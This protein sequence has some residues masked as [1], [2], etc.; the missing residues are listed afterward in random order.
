MRL[1]WTSGLALALVLVVSGC[2][3]PST[4]CDEGCDDGIACTVDSC[5]EV[6]GACRH[7]PDHGQCTQPEVCD[8]DNGCTLP[9]GACTNDAACDDT[10]PCTSDT[11]NLTSGSCVHG[12]LV[13]QSCD[14]G[15]VCTDGDECQMNGRCAG[16]SMQCEDGDPCTADSCDPSTLG[17]ISVPAA[18]A[19]CSDGDACTTGDVCQADGSCAG[20][21]AVTC[22]DGNECTNDSCDPTTG[23]VAQ[24]VLGGACDDGDA[25]T[26]G[27]TCQADG[28]CGGGSGVTCDDSNPCT[29]DSCDLGGNCVYE[30][31]PGGAC[32]DSDLCTESTT[33]QA[34]GSCGGGT[35]V[36]C[37]RGNG[38]ETFSC[39]PASGCIYTP[40]TGA[41]CDDNDA[42][43]SGTT[44]Q[45]DAS[46]GGGT[47]TNCGDGNACTDDSC[48]P[49]TGA[50]E[51]PI[52]ITNPC[53]DAD[54]CTL[55][56]ACQTDGT[57]AGTTRNCDD[58]NPCTNDSC[59]GGSGDCVSNDTGV[60]SS[61][62]WCRLQWPL[63]LTA[64]AGTS[65]TFYGRV[66]ITGITSQ[67][68]GV[69]ASAPLVA[70]LGWGPDGSDP[71]LPA[72]G[73][74]W[75]TAQANA[76]WSAAGAGEPNND[77]YE[78]TVPLPAAAGSPYDFAFRFSHDYG[79]TWLYC[80]RDATGTGGADGSGDGYAAADAGQ[81]VTN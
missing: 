40:D 10:N 7:T 28:S 29:A 9:S 38:C 46:C 81:L 6:A 76:G 72:S 2:P 24:P 3:G 45:A 23:C 66:Y 62:D 54:L 52:D 56:D 27:T 32:D 63:D 69:D 1:F 60:C 4:G 44:C 55:S 50:C 11:C 5:D 48:N 36:N 61:V 25:C 58:G 37:D 77:E 78:A 79:Q 57:C 47:T 51:N 64:A 68:D 74:T 8:T 20:P 30:P 39:N 65:T 34:D 15:D 22:D 42:C 80:D 71:S 43:T 13:G 53:S 14:D 19:P 17:C 67:S 49:S 73:W 41:V 70:E 35:T 18:G 26:S 12:I 75:N 31:A 21:T 59:D 33:C 16:A